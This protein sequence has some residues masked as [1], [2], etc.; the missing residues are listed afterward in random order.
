MNPKLAKTLWKSKKFRAAL[1][2]PPVFAVALIILLV[3]MAGALLTSAQEAQAEANNAYDAQCKETGK[4]PGITFTGEMDVVLRTMRIHESS[5]N[6]SLAPGSASSAAGAYQ[7]LIGTWNSPEVKAIWSKH[8]NFSGGAHTA[9]PAVQDEVA[10]VEIGKILVN[11]SV[12][13]VGVIW[14]LGHEPKG[15]E[16]DRKPPSNVITPRE[17]QARWMNVYNRVKNEKNH[18]PNPNAPTPKTG[19]NSPITTMPDNSIVTTTIPGIVTCNTSGAGAPPG[20]LDP[21]GLPSGPVAN[22]DI[23]NV[24]GINIHKSVSSN[25][26]RMLTAMKAAGLNPGGGGYRDPAGQINV[27]RNNCGTSHYAIYEMPN[28]SCSPPT[29][30]PGTSMHERGLAIDF[31]CGGGGTLSAG[32]PC[33]SWLRL[34]AANYGFINWP[35]EPWHWST[36]GH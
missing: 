31:T 33:H 25:L 35:V 2:G 20:P 18:P 30:K 1:I 9:P 11:H 27:R 10:N 24:Q 28:K 14:F 22:T 4:A 36:N 5:D 8:G 16:W 32:S 34:N 3:I 26:D 19:P 29:A 15:A 21:N 17:Y 7:F 13:L 12:D 23:V 6:Y